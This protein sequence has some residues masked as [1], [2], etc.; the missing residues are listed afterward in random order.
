MPRTTHPDHFSATKEALRLRLEQIDSIC[1]RLESEVGLPLPSVRAKTREAARLLEP[2]RFHIAL[3][4]AFSDGKSTLIGALTK[5]FDIDV[6]IAPT[7]DKVTPYPCDAWELID[8]PGLFSDTLLHDAVTRDY[9]SKAHAVLY[10]V[11]AV[12]PLPASHHATLRWLLDDLQKADVTIFVINRMDD[13][14]DLDDPVDFRHWSDTK[15]EVVRATLRDA[16]GAKVDP[17][18]TVAVA[19]DPFGQGLEYWL[20][21]EDEYVALSRI[22][23]L[24]DVLE[25]FLEDAAEELSSKV[26][27]SV[28]CDA[29]TE[30]AAGI[31]ELRQ[32]L[33]TSR[34]VVQHQST[35]LLADVAKL[36]RLVNDAYVG[37]REA[38][39][40]YR[41][42]LLMDLDALPDAA[43]L[44]SFLQTHVGSEGQ[45]IQR[46]IEN[47][48]LDGTK[49]LEGNFDPIVSSIVAT[50]E[51]TGSI[52]AE[53]VAKHGSSVFAATLQTALSAP[54]KAVS[55]SLLRIRDALK[56]PI[57]FRPWGAQKLARLLKK[58]AWLGPL[59]EAL[60]VAVAELKRYTLG[61]NISALRDVLSTH[62][63]AFLTSFDRDE[64]AAEACPALSQILELEAQHRETTTTLQRKLHILIEARADLQRLATAPG[65]A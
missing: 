39:D 42:E 29:V 6:D 28:V 23:A 45:V 32:Q 36:K 46:R 54:T 44:Q 57:R 19:A 9:I 2:E 48:L 1:A 58:L 34:D 14:A 17:I 5:R 43:A 35:E 4:G 22:P 16:C 59:L 49:T 10:V 64:F 26:G 25:R 13:V 55:G 24:S 7:T 15:S 30:V 40:G 21:R 38:V 27:I 60:P 20:Q 56:L 31:E 62:F 33:S 63:D 18:R 51:E 11:N 37:I 53:L 52:L 47:L 12:T 8:T 50:A 61:K 3:F 41:R 65:T